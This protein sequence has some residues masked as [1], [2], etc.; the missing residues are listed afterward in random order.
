MTEANQK[1]LY[2][3]FK[4]FS[5]KGKTEKIRNDCKKAAAQILE[6]FPHFEKVKEEVKP[7]EEV[8]PKS[9][10]KEK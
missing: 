2:E 3:N 10:S 1:I 5:E 9:K 4:V 8:K 6:S 7:V